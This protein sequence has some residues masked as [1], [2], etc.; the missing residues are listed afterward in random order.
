MRIIIPMA[1]MGKRMRPHT[2][3]TP[4]PLIPVAGKP[5]VE[6]LVEDLAEI[7]QDTI[8]EIAFVTGRFGQ[9]TEEQLHLVARHVGARKTSI[10]Y[11][12]NPL[13]TAHAILCASPSL[14]GN[15]MVAFADTLFQA[16]FHMNHDADGVIWVKKIEDPSAFGV[17]KVNEAGV[18]SEFVEKPKSFVSD[19]AIIGIYYFKDGD[20]LRKELQYLID[21]DI[22]EKGEYQLTNALENMKNKGKIF[23]PAEVDQWLDCGN[24]NITL[25]TN[26]QVLENKRNKEKLIHDSVTLEKTEIIEPCYLGE[27]VV[28]RNSIIGP[29]V[30]VGKNTV[31]ENSVLK[32]CIIQHNTSISGVVL[33]N[34]MIGAHVS[35][36]AK[37]SC[38]MELSVGDYNELIVK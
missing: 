34:S 10:Y 9:E 14:K 11:Q 31:I 24:K 4:K 27:N 8:E 7:A 33:Q 1:G 35:I 30:S 19:L 28:I 3:T 18:I 29:Y 25:E 20:N 15:V 23:V 6:R 2:L 32:N 21:K 38:E 36:L 22:K 16:H 37:Q 17:V 13:G 5:I 26:A 12:E